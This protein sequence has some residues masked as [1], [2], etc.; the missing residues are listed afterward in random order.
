MMM[1][2]GKN[3]IPVENNNSISSS[4]DSSLG[5]LLSVNTCNSNTYFN[6][7]NDKS[8]NYSFTTCRSVASSTPPSSPRSPQTARDTGPTSPTPSIACETCSQLSQLEIEAYSAV[9]EIAPYVRSIS[10]SEVL[11]RTSELM[12][13]NLVTLENE[14]Y[15]IELTQKGWRICSDRLDCMYGDF[16]KI[17]MH[18]QYYDTIYALLDSL[19]QLYRD[20][21]SADLAQRLGELAENQQQPMQ[22]GGTAAEIGGFGRTRTTSSAEENGFGHIEQLPPSSMEKLS[23]SD[24]VIILKRKHSHSS[25]STP[26]RQMSS[27]TLHREHSSENCEIAA[28]V[29]HHRRQP[30][31]EWRNGNGAATAPVSR[32]KSP[33]PSFTANHA[34]MQRELQELYDQ[35]QAETKS[36]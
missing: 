31:A 13:L 8:P 14:S 2:S 4:N 15:C 33:P 7:S 3:S 35:Q 22:N 5:G 29:Q 36:E 9:R 26:S 34:R 30:C 24:G 27:S 20:E 25:S 17:D 21:F 28:T 1:M 18:V 11:T 6:D 12:F 23:Q 32:P 19:S 10:V 16:R